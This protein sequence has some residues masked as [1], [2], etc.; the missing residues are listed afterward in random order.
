M[1]ESVV[2]TPSLYIFTKLADCNKILKSCH[3]RLGC[4][5]GILLIVDYSF[6]RFV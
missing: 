3:V 6:K 5:D 2:C 4:A 1:A